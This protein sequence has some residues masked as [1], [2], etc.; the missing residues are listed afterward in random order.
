MQSVIKRNTA[1]V[2][3]FFMAGMISPCLLSKYPPCYIESFSWPDKN[4]AESLRNLFNTLDRFTR[5][6]FFGDEIEVF[7]SSQITPY[8][9]QFDSV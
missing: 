9:P 4:T 2:D 6:V 8:H 3:I 7:H 5:K 1:P